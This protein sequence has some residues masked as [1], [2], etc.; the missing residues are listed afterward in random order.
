[1]VLLVTQF[2]WRLSNLSKMIINPNFRRGTQTPDNEVKGTSRFNRVNVG[3]PRID[4]GKFQIIIKML[5][6]DNFFA[7]L[8]E[9]YSAKMFYSSISYGML[10]SSFLKTSMKGL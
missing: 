4:G 3:Y 1:M 10:Q 5:K 8:K 7:A 2:Y 9:Q 6:V